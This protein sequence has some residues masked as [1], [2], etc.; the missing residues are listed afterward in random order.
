[1]YNVKFACKCSC[2]KTY[3]VTYSKV[4]DKKI[5]KSVTGSVTYVNL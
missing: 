1:M 2:Y 4:R 3:C 5:S